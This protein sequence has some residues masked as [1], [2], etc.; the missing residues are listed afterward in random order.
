MIRFLFRVLAVLAFA[1]ALMFAVIDATRSIGVSAVVFTPFSESFE[2]AAPVLLENIRAW[3]AQLAQNAPEYV[4]ADALA[5]V[6]ALPT[7]AVFAALAFVFYV[8]GRK[9]RP[10]GLRRNRH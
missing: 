7:F 1:I 2:L 5:S 4:S 10:R 8:F 9:P 3:Y 6:L